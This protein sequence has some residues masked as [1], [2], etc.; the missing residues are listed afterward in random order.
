MGIISCKFDDETDHEIR[1]LARNMHLSNSEIVRIMVLR[2]MEK[3]DHNDLK[4]L[5]KKSIKLNSHIL[6]VARLTAPKE[7]Q[8]IDKTLADTILKYAQNYYDSALEHL[9]DDPDE[10]D[11]RVIDLDQ[12]GVPTA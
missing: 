7:T 10:D 2:G 9:D 12:D 5:L 8:R 1:I 6:A 3:T 11:N 4:K